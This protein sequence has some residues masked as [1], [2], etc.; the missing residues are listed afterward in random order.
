MEV[1]VVG[2]SG[3]ARSRARKLRCK[4]AR[5]ARYQQEATQRG[6]HVLQVPFALWRE[7]QNELAAKKQR[8]HQRYLGQ[9]DINCGWATMKRY[10]NAHLRSRGIW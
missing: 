6:I 7:V 8:D 10:L 3:Q 2:D 5:K 4:Q 9:R 1:L